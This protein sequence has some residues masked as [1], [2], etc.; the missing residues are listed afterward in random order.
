MKKVLVA[1]TILLLSLVLLAG[2]KEQVVPAD[3]EAEVAAAE[4]DAEASS[5]LPGSEQPLADADEG[6]PAASDDGQESSPE[7]VTE[8]PPA[9]KCGDGVCNGA[10]NCDRCIKDCGCVS[11]AE[12]YQGGCKVPECGSK[13]DCKDNDSCTVDECQFAQHPNA[14]CSHEVI[15]DFRNN[16]GCCPVKADANTDSDCEPVC[17]NDVCEMGENS[18]N[19]EEDCP[20]QQSQAVCGNG[21]CES[22]EDASSCPR[23]C[24]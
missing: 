10:E 6:V 17:D 5:E 20:D 14:Y 23:D 7:Q 4:V 8:T 16:D 2:C 12:C 15:K 21:D 19:C 1:F 9:P 24:V 3:S 13:G 11:P 18:D 22:G